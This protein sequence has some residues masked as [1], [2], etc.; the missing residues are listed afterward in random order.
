MV[1]IIFDYYKLYGIIRVSIRVI[2]QLLKSP[3]SCSGLYRIR[4]MPIFNAFPN[5]S[6]SDLNE[7]II[8]IHTLHLEFL[9]GSPF[10]HFHYKIVSATFMDFL[11]IVT[12]V[13]IYSVSLRIEIRVTINRKNHFSRVHDVFH[14]SSFGVKGAI[15]TCVLGA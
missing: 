13:S 9:A 7:T 3:Y 11:K 4:P 8:G 14:N 2:L 12:F 6:I 10:A 15:K 5:L 1:L